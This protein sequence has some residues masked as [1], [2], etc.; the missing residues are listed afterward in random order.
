MTPGKAGGYGVEYGFQSPAG[1]CP[2]AFRERY[3]IFEVSLLYCDL[4][5]M[6]RRAGFFYAD[7]CRKD[8]LTS[9]PWWIF[10]FRE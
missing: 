6:P 7:T 8:P 2:G 5:R 3:K 1:A 4:P 9:P 10:W